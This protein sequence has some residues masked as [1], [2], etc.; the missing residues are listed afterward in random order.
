MRDFAFAIVTIICSLVF[1]A[2]DSGK[3]KRQT[4]KTAKDNLNMRDRGT[5]GRDFQ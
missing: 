1:L 4:L 5:W 2:E 3:K